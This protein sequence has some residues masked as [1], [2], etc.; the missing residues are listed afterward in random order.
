MIK[1]LDGREGNGGTDLMN[2]PCS[3]LM[4]QLSSLNLTNHA[5][6]GRNCDALSRN[7]ALLR[8]KQALA[9]TGEVIDEGWLS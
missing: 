2:S 6:G 8:E 7:L 4:S 3:A 9:A 1:Q 5:A